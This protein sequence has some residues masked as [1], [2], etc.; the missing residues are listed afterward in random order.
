MGGHG[1][2]EMNREIGIDVCALL[3]IKHLADTFKSEFLGE[4][5]GHNNE[6]LPSN[7]LSIAGV[8]LERRF[9]SHLY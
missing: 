1:R 7:T 5:K 2:G 6:Q 9:L 3:C 4:G 8:S